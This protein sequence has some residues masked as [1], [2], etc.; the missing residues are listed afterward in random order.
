MAASTFGQIGV[1]VKGGVPLTDLFDSDSPNATTDTKKYIIGPM[2][3]LRLP[4][5]LGIEFNALYTK[6]DF[7]SVLDA[8]G[9]VTTSA[10][11]TSAWEFP[12]LLKYKFGGANAV[13]ASVRP[14]IEAGASF[15]RLSDVGNIGAFITGNQGGELDR[16]NTGF[17]IGG[18][19]EIRALFLR[20]A[21]ELRFTHWG[22][23]HFTEGLG[24]IWKTNKNQGQFLV[25]LY[26]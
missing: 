6:A 20:I 7:S 25:G 16:N 2:I 9:S 19:L 17:V 13:A 12:L 5:G 21:P 15:R 3:E 22:N 11:D 4:A 24:D 14:Y 10:F 18:G 8:A 1:G 23:D 26:F